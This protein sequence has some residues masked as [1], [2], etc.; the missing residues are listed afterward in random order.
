MRHSVRI[1][2]VSLFS[3]DALCVR[4]RAESGERRMWRSYERGS[5]A[6]TRM[7][8]GFGYFSATYT[9]TF[10]VVVGKYVGLIV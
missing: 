5:R 6:T 1:G 10:S 3:H 7:I 4:R 2:V 8:A 9:V